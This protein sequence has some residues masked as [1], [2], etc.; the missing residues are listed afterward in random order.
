MAVKEIDLVIDDILL[1]LHTYVNE[2]QII[3]IIQLMVKLIEDEA[4]K[5]KYFLV[6]PYS[7]GGDIEYDSAICCTNLAFARSGEEA[8]KLTNSKY[9]NPIV[10]PI[11]TSEEGYFAMKL[12]LAMKSR[13]IV[14]STESVSP[15]QNISSKSI[16]RKS[17][18]VHS[19][20]KSVTDND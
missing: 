17:L 6:L 11:N 7:A 15:T 8:C 2:T 16:F 13:I 1:C 4:R 10:L 18:F 12:S 5:F 9:G 19:G 14:K 3:K 20:I